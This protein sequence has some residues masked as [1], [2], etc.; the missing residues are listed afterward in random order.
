MTFQTVGPD[1]ILRERCGRCRGAGCGGMFA[2]HAASLCQAASDS[3]SSSRSCRAVTQF[4]A[5]EGGGPRHTRPVRHAS[6]PRPGRALDRQCRYP[7][8]RRAAAAI[9]VNPMRHKPRH[10]A[11][12]SGHTRVEVAVHRTRRSACPC[13]ARFRSGRTPAA[14]SW[15]CSFGGIVQLARLIMGAVAHAGSGGWGIATGVAS[16]RVHQPRCPLAL[17]AIFG[18][19]N[20]GA[21]GRSSRTRLQIALTR[22]AVPAARLPGRVCRPDAAAFRMSSGRCG[23]AGGRQYAEACRGS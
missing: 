6:A 3:N 23:H 1:R 7:S 18:N 16:R 21:G 20:P 9:C 12:L 13:D 15:N 2:R 8:V 11:A 17:P 22:H 10:M 19:P 5:S 14:A 4:V